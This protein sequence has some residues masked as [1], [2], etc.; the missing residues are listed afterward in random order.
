MVLLESVGFLYSRIPRLFSSGALYKPKSPPAT[1]LRK[2]DANKYRADR[3]LQI[4]AG[5]KEGKQCQGETNQA[6]QTSKNARLNTSKRAM[7]TK[8]F[9]RK[10]LSGAPGQQ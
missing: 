9:L 4:V 10:N 8:A 2:H 5:N 3:D 6:T 1:R 7:K